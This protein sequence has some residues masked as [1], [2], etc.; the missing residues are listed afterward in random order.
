MDLR[1]LRG[2]WST[3]QQHSFPQPAPE[4]TRFVARYWIVTWDLRGQAPY[5]QLIVPYP[6]VHLSFLGS[7]ANVYGVARGY[8]YRVLED[9]GR[10]FGVAFRPGCFRPFLRAPVSTITDRCVPAY[11]VFGP[12]LPV[13]AITLAADE[14]TMVRVMDGFLRAIAPEPEPTAESVTAMVSAIAEDPSIARVH[15]LADRFV[16][17]PRRLQR[18]FAEYV[19]VGPKWVIRGYRLHEVT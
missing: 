6:N 17:S 12:D 1:G 16:T 11:E 7:I 8:V 13:S 3:F 4:L 14:A 2:G 18:L 5:R 19:G 15:E 10:V 9:A